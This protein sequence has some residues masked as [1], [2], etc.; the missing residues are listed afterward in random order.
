M[1]FQ[2]IQ[3]TA[4]GDELD[5]PYS[6]PIRSARILIETNP[7]PEPDYD[8]IQIGRYQKQERRSASGRSN[9]IGGPMMVVNIT[10]IGVHKHCKGEF[11]LTKIPKKYTALHCEE[12]GLRVTF[13]DTV[14]TYGDL[15]T[16]M[17]NALTID[18]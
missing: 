2:P 5:I 12:C 1:P 11:T 4:D 7:G 13:P 10:L 6:P 3:L 17:Q 18:L 14:R 8:N 9:V 15:R 16:H